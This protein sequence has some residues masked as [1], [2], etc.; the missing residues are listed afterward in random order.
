MWDYF[1]EEAETDLHIAKYSS[2]LNI[3][4]ITLPCRTLDIGCGTGRFAMALKKTGHDVV[5]IDSSEFMINVFRTKMKGTADIQIL[6]TDFAR[7]STDEKFDGIVAFY[8]MQFILEIDDIMNFFKKVYS[9]LNEKGVF[10]FAVYN[11][12]EIWNPS[13]WYATYAS[14]MD[15]GFRKIDITFNPIYKEKGLCYTTDY[16]VL[17][18]DD[19][20]YIDFY[21]KVIRL[22]TLKEY[23]LMLRLA[24]FSNVSFTV[25][26][27]LEPSE[28]ITSGMKLYISATN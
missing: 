28:S 13:G 11:T 14:E 26:Q 1:F 8:V 24:G 5:G 10:M 6:H 9:L 15:K 7:Y 27:Y 25:D 23:I 19:K 21:S 2:V 16:R 18:I 17:C 4:G 22:Y 20:Y 3:S 12:L